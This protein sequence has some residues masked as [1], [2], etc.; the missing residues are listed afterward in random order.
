M[1]NKSTVVQSVQVKVENFR[2]GNRIYW[3]TLTGGTD[4]GEFS[5]KVFVNGVGPSGVS[6][7]PATY[8]TLKPY[9]A[10]AQNEIR[11]NIPPR[12]VICLVIDKK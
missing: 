5:R 8:A 3:Y 1:V 7:G 4:N 12:S 11:L 2:V 6:G 10:S 9:S